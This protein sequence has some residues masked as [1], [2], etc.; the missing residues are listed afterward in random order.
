MANARLEQLADMLAE[1][2]DDPLRLDL[3][4]RAQGFKRSW[5][6]LAEALARVRDSRAYEGWGYATLHEYGQKELSIKPATVDKLVV[7]FATVQRH[8]PEALERA[9]RDVPTLDA[10]DYFNRVSPPPEAEMRGRRL[11]APDDVVEQLRAAVFDE[12]RGVGELRQRFNPILNATTPEAQARDRV[13]RLRGAARRLEQMLGEVE[14]LTE[15]RV[16]RVSAALEA[17]VKDLDALASAEPAPAAMKKV[18]R[19]RGRAKQA[20]QAGEDA[21][22]RTGARRRRS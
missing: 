13:R 21:T 18:A 11:D 22:A 14:G 17:L 10:V 20:A 8:I 16:A 9:D 15:A 1:S 19:R 7:S 3:V 12:G 4:R 2:G 5:V 6:E